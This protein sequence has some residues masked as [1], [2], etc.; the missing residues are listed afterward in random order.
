MREMLRPDVLTAFSR[1]LDIAYDPG[2]PG[3]RRRETQILLTKQ[4][5]AELDGFVRAA[6][7]AVEKESGGHK[8][9]D[10]VNETLLERGKTEQVAKVTAKLNASGLD[11]VSRVLL[12]T[13]GVYASLIGEAIDKQIELDDTMGLVSFVKRRL[14]APDG[15]RE[16]FSRQLVDGALTERGMDIGG[17]DSTA[18]RWVVDA[19]M[20]REV[21]L[22]ASKAEAAIIG[23]VEGVREKGLIAAAVNRFAQ[24][25]EIDPA[26][27]TPTVRRSMIEYLDGLGIQFR[28]E[29]FDE[30]RYDEYLALA[31]NQAVRSSNG[32]SADPIDAIRHK[33]AMPDWDFTVDTFE[34]VEEQG[35][36]PENVRAAGALDYVYHLGEQLGI[37]RLA[38]ALVLHWARGTMDLASAETSAKLYRFWKLRSER[39]TAEERAM[40]Y[41]RVLNKG[42]GQLLSGMVANED[43]PALWGN[44]MTEVA[45]YIRRSEENGDEGVS[46]QP[47][48]Q[49]TKQLQFNLTEHM[50]GMALMQT[51][52]M[53]HHLME[54]KEILEDEQIV[55][56]F[57]AGRRKNI[58]AVIER[59]SK[60]W[61]DTAPNIAALRTLAVDGNRVFQWIA[62]FD[63]PTVTEEQFE[64]FRSAAESW[65]LAQAVAGGEEFGR[66]RGDELEEEEDEFDDFGDDDFD[67][68][69]DV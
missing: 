46:R 65:I 5:R 67:S 13:P 11:N 59:A 9:I 4:P 33:G 14:D 64:A 39:T 63:Q 51:T 34:T 43:F 6:A 62:D 69:W 60:E 44:L 66:G 19:V 48:F 10:A 40:L 58:W 35:V 22:R 23:V 57:G 2:A 28:E 7:D 17:P 50:T 29:G 30:G 52:E 21:P 20:N 12:S 68:D 31:Y 15:A 38:E 26:R 61:F 37:I 3:L 25:E 27:L 1:G 56:F 54:A 42:D 16:F 53:Y 47:V 49:A 41:K 8:T 36:I 45:E 24:R 18:Y 32:G 55:D